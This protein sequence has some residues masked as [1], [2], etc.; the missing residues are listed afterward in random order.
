M[1]NDPET[2]MVKVAQGN[3]GL[4]QRFIQTPSQ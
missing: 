2:L 3:R 1:A 4:A